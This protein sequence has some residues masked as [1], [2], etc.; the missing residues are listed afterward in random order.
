MRQ[1]EDQAFQF[2]ALLCGNI[3]QK[4]DHVD[5]EKDT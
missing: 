1:Y 3:K 4:L 2:I 5:K